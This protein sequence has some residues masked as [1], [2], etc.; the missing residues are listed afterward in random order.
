MAL[1]ASGVA[2]SPSMST[3]VDSPNPPPNS[4]ASVLKVATAGESSGRK[5]V[6]L[7]RVSSCVKPKK[8]TPPRMRERTSVG[9]GACSASTAVRAASLGKIRSVAPAARAS[10]GR[11]PARSALRSRSKR[12]AGTKVSMSRNAARIPT[13]ERMPKSAR[14]GTGLTTLVRNP[15]AVVTVARIKATPTVPIARP[16]AADTVRPSPSSSR[17]LAVRWMA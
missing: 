6:K 7:N 15:T 2:T 11:R 13:A 16:V 3:E 12:I 8:P 10:L 4:S 17:Y 5:S 1:C 14:A 9:T